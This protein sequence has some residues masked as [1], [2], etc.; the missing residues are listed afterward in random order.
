M[1]LTGYFA[2]IALFLKST[3][4]LINNYKRNKQPTQSI[5]SLALELA[6]SAASFIHV[7]LT[8]YSFNIVKFMFGVTSAL[9]AALF[10]LQHCYLKDSKRIIKQEIEQ[11]RSEDEVR[12]L[13]GEDRGTVGTVFYSCYD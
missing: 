8:A 5:L 12:P 9:F 13:R 2:V 4:A 11:R 1:L 7:G 3:P 10:L 6:G